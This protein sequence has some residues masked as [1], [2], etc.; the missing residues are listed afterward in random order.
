[1]R[2]ARFDV[3]VLVETTAPETAREVQATS[4]YLYRLA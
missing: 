2:P 1:V 4:A 3:V